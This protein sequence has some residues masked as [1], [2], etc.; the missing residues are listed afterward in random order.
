MP[1]II[2]YYVIRTCPPK[3]K[4]RKEFLRHTRDWKWRYR[5]PTETDSAFSSTC[6]R[7]KGDPL[8]TPLWPGQWWETL[9]GDDCELE[10]GHLAVRWLLSNRSRF[11]DP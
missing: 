2:P 1:D 11:S 7:G 10:N 3:L 5:K 6:M 9:A 4:R 8:G